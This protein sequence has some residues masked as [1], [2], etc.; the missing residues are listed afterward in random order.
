M[1]A[2]NSNSLVFLAVVF[3]LYWTGSRYRLLRMAV[4]LAANYLFCIHFGP[5]YIVLIPACSMLDFLAG[6][7]LMRFRGIGIRRFL[8]GL[9]L[10]VNLALLAF[11]RE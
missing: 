5:I 7:G 1:Q 6:L 11:L 4:I 8:V 2:G 9:S 10:A 3:F